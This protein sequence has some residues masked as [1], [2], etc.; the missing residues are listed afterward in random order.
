MSMWTLAAIMAIFSSS[1]GPAVGWH[2]A[3][4]ILRKAR[5]KCPPSAT[6]TPFLLPPSCCGC[7]MVSGTGWFF[8]QALSKCILG[9]NQPRKQQI[10]SSHICEFQPFGRG[11]HKFI[12][13][14][15]S[16]TDA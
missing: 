11:N 4:K 13:E 14:S 6:E 7:R 10:F 16:I 12:L 8:L 2:L 3:A 15:W 9:G 5:I 1:H